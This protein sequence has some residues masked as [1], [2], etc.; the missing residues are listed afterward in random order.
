MYWSIFK[1]KKYVREI[2]EDCHTN[3][4]SREGQPGKSALKILAFVWA[5]IPTRG[6]A[7]KYGTTLYHET[8]PY[9]M[10]NQKQEFS[11]FI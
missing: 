2:L 3:L 6:T 4:P 1:K 8:D 10:I 9:R 11:H 7:M 5:K